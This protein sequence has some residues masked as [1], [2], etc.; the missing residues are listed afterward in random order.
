MTLIWQMLVTSKSKVF[1]IKS[2]MNIG[3]S[4]IFVIEIEKFFLFVPCRRT[5]RIGIISESFWTISSI[6]YIS[7]NYFSNLYIFFFSNFLKVDH[8]TIRFLIY[9]NVPRFIRLKS[10]CFAVPHRRNLQQSRS[11]DKCVNLRIE[12]LECINLSRASHD[13]GKWFSKQMATYFRFSWDN[14]TL[15]T[16]FPN[17]ITSMATITSTHRFV[18]VVSRRYYRV[19]WRQSSLFGQREVLRLFPPIMIT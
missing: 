11:N 9:L 1:G 14:Y 13:F 5:K 12:I 18:I 2:N 16:F 10:C 7:I 17:S 6:I 15:Q 3:R 19:L 8:P 4:G